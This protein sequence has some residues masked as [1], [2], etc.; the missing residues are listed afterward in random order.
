VESFPALLA[1]ELVPVGV[2]GKLALNGPI[3]TLYHPRLGYI[4]ARA[5][6]RGDQA[7][8]ATQQVG[9]GAPSAVHFA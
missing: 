6:F 1:H 4:A 5:F 3:H 7:D 2:V 8:T 9:I